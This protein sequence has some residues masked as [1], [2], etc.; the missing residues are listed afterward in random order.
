MP[1]ATNTSSENYSSDPALAVLQ[2]EL[3]KLELEYRDRRMRLIHA[4]TAL[5]GD[6]ASTM[7]PE[8]VLPID[9][10]RARMKAVDDAITAMEREFTSIQIRDYINANNL[11]EVA[12]ATK[13]SYLPT[14]LTALAN[15]PLPR[16]KLVK[17]GESGAPN[18]WAKLNP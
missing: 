17:Q 18:R 13:G 1:I 7:S 8:M 9:V 4:I 14:R 2:K 3:K 11:P 10:Q 15:A 12:K 5:T 6:P 16:I